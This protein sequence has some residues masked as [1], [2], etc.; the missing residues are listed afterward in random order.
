MKQTTI[1]Q[2]IRVLSKLRDMGICDEKAIG[3]TDLDD[4]V[5]KYERMSYADLRIIAALKK[6]VKLNRLYSYL[7]G[8]EAEKNKGNR[9]EENHEVYS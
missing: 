6:A 7:Q 3:A 4:I 2:K 9:E 8:A 5:I 1:T